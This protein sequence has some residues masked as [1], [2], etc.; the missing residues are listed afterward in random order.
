MVAAL[1]VGTQAVALDA[2]A[3]VL[4]AE[5]V[6]V[7]TH[8]HTDV[9]VALVTDIVTRVEDATSD[10]AL[11]VVVVVR[12]H[13]HTGVALVVDEDVGVNVRTSPL[14]SFSPSNSLAYNCI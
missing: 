10:A 5:D 6:G 2:S 7:H 1:A 11:G 12:A 8:A 3:V 4:V 9:A 14:C 13:I